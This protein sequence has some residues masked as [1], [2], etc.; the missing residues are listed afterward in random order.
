M[1]LRPQWEWRLEGGQPPASPVFTTQ[2]DAEQWVGESWRALAAQGVTRVTLLH[3]GE[4]ATPPLDV[5]P[6]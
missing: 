2:Y 5:P 3:Q 1:A 4:P 6:A